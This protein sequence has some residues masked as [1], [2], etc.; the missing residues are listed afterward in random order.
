MPTRYPGTA[1]EVRA[2]DVLIK[3]MRAAMTVKARLD[4]W[5]TAQ[6]L[7]ETQFGVLETLYFLGPLSPSTI[8]LKRL[9]SGAN[10]TTVLDN[11]EKR[12]L[13]RREQSQEDRRCSRVHLLP[14][15]RRLIARIFP[16]HVT[17]TREVFSAL[18]PAEQETLAALSRKL[19]L[20]N[21]QAASRRPPPSRRR[22]SAK[23]RRPGQSA[24]RKKNAIARMP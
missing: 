12:E 4:R 24:G 6:G 10:I 15:G 16:A 19:G 18:T 17:E 21:A 23:P 20:A 22:A 8:G 1:A 7:T 9:S 3:L 11:L 5:V 13:V 2:L 14:E